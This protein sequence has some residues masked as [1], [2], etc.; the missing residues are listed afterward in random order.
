[1]ITSTSCE[2][3]LVLDE[4]KEALITY[5]FHDSSVPPEYHR[6][7]EITI[8]KNEVHCVVDSYGDILQ[9]KKNDIND[10]QYTKLIQ[11]IN[12]A[13]LKPY[14][15]DTDVQCSGGTSENLKITQG[16]K[17]YSA[18]L[19]HCGKN[20]YPSSSGNIEGVIQQIKALVPNLGLLL[21]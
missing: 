17:S 3:P 6:S 8:T 10:S 18:S 20:A 14:A 11:F 9:D 7:Y 5:R 2:S 12:D 21:N 4:T 15:S 16:D 13:K 19:D 1:M